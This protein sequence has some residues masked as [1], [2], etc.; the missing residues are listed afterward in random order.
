MDIFF[1]ADKP[2]QVFMDS[3]SIC[4][5]TSIADYLANNGYMETLEMFKR[6]AALSGEADGR[7]SGLL[8]KRWTAILRM[9]KKVLLS[10]FFAFVEVFSF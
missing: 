2:D 8:E 3:L 6:E 5:H 10:S 7:F 1:Y 4:R 9:A